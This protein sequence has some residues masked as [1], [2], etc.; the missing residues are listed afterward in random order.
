MILGMPVSDLVLLLFL[1]IG[2]VMLGGVL[3]AFFKVS[4]YYYLFSLLAI[5]V[6]HFLLKYLNRKKHP[7]FIKSAI[8]YLWMQPGKIEITRP[9]SGLFEPKS[10]NHGE[11]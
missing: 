10:I 3:G 11:K 2:L 8:S 4:K 1:L 9:V 5:V 7:T 6:L